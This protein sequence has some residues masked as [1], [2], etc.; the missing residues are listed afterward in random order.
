LRGDYAK[1]DLYAAAGVT[2]YWIVNLPEQV[3]EVHRQ[4]DAEEYASLSRYG[5]G[6]KLPL[7][8]F[9]D[10]ALEVDDILPPSRRPQHSPSFASRHEGARTWL[11]RGR[12]LRQVDW[13]PCEARARR[14]RA[15]GQA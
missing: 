2:E 6:E 3:L 15:W 4:P 9:E 13:S 11:R 8:A 12:R 1:A 14:R 5:R 10:V 7:A